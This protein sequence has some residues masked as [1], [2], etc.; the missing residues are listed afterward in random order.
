[1]HRSL[2]KSLTGKPNA[3]EANKR[4][5]AAGLMERRGKRWKLTEAGKAY[6]EEKPYVSHGH[7]DYQIVWSE[8][9]YKVLK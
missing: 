3:V 8:R 4:L 7:S 6:G 2:K 9:V 1:M 5:E